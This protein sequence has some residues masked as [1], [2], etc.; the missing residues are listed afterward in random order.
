MSTSLALPPVA[1]AAWPEGP[2]SS[3]TGRWLASTKRM[4]SASG[5]A[6]SR[7]SCIHQFSF[8]LC[9]TASLA[10]ARSY[11][12]VLTYPCMVPPVRTE[13]RLERRVVD[14]VEQ[15][16][17]VEVE[18]PLKRLFLFPGKEVR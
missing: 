1:T 15:E 12:N 3:A 10:R 16:V 4:S 13:K 7:V 6:L 5:L 11:D 8:Y 18:L 9:V 14:G 2:A 17:E